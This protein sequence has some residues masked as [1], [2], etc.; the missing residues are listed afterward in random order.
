M[1]LGAVYMLPE[2]VHSN[3]TYFSSSHGLRNAVTTFRSSTRHSGFQSDW[4]DM[5]FLYQSIRHLKSC[6]PCLIHVGCFLF[7]SGF[8]LSTNDAH[9]ITE[10]HNLRAERRNVIN[11]SVRTIETAYCS[12]FYLKFNSNIYRHQLSPHSNI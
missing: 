7:S 1:K 11:F 4:N 5:S 3:G 10:G 9:M 2:Q 8:S 12:T 6:L